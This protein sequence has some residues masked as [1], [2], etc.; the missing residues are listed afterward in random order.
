MRHGR[1][2]SCCVWLT[3]GLAVLGSLSAPAAAQEMTEGTMSYLHPK[4]YQIADITVSGVNFLMAVFQLV[5]GVDAVPQ[6][7]R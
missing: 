5:D 6:A 1:L 7:R 2:L 4:E 3:C